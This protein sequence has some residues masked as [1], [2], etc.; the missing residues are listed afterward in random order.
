MSL[1]EALTALTLSDAQL[2][3]MRDQLAQEIHTGLS[4]KGQRIKAL[5]AYLRL[6]KQNIA[7]DAFVLD[8]GGTNV[9]A[10]HVALKNNHIEL[11]KGPIADKTLMFDAQ[12]PGEVSSEA[13]FHRQADLL[14]QLT[15]PA[16]F[17]S[18]YCFSYPSEN[19][20]D[21]DASLIN[22]TKNINIDGMVGESI[23]SQ[24]TQAIAQNGQAAHK[25]PV[26]ND[27]VTTLIAAA[28]MNANCDQYM[29]LIAGTGMNIAGFFRT[30]QITKLDANDIP[31]WDAK[32]LMAVNLEL[33]NFHPACLTQ[34]DDELDASNPHDSPTRQRLEKAI[35]GRYIASI[36]GQVV[37]REACLA[38]PES[39]RFDPMDIENS[40]AVNVTRLR[41]YPG[42]MGEIANAIINRSADLVAA[43]LAGVVK[44]QDLPL[45]QKQVVGLLPEGSLFWLTEGY[46]DRV[47]KTL[48]RLT[49]TNVTV[50]I[51][52][53]TTG[54]DSNFIGA[55]CAALS[56]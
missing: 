17:T 35:S 19:K 39:L 50:N 44:A 38:L 49:P 24:L 21:G 41:N 4:Q 37:G 10:A 18:A 40:N 31:H 42:Q 52:Q 26:L 54:V 23:R 16:E 27:T 47:E 29:G 2:T 32:E 25:M 34:Y 53:N 7:G 9:R 8:A 5:P 56:M 11:I 6:P 33:G 20:P 48:D 36:Y 30:E 43:A 14:N 45:D 22:W 51:M 46:R 13:F 15:P 1:D 55:A 28:W 3:Q 12:T